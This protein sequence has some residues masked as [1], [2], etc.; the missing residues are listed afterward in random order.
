[1]R[2]LLVIVSIIGLGTVVATMIVGSSRFEQTVVREPYETGLRW[3]AERKEREHSGWRASLV[4]KRVP[5][6]RQVLD[7]AVTD[8]D[9]RP[10]KEVTVEVRFLRPFSGMED[11][12]YRAERLPAGTFR[13]SVVIPERGRWDLQIIVSQ[14]DRRILFED[15][16]YAE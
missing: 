15:A 12:P 13:I 5:T 4:K 7:I 14:G 16:I 11:R 6:G 10:L 8:R 9:S 1:V 3:D 2:T